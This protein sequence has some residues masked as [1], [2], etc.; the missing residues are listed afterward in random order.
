MDTPLPLPPIQRM[1]STPPEYREKD[2][3]DDEAKMGE[4]KQGDDDENDTGAQTNDRL[5]RHTVRA[6][7]LAQISPTPYFVH[8]NKSPWRLVSR[9]VKKINASGGR[10]HLPCLVDEVD[11]LSPS[12]SASQSPTLSDP[13]KFSFWCASNLPLSESDRLALLETSST[14]ERL[15]LVDQ[16]VEELSS[17][18]SPIVCARCDQSLSTV[19]NV[20]TVQGAEG[21]T[22]AYVNDHGYIHQ[23][24][25]LRHVDVQSIVLEGVPHEEN[26]YFPGYSWTVCYCRSC[27]SLLGWMFRRVHHNMPL[28]RDRPNAFFG[29][30]SSSVLVLEGRNPISPPDHSVSDSDEGSTSSSP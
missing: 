12:P 16:H 25:T 22:S 9:V 21:T 4:T 30:Q 1:F 27:L 18:N 29:F 2:N 17:T 8:R 24:T 23:I 11:A 5:Y 3:L 13:T 19:Q 7:C 14:Y 10:N 15:L 20:F 28:S 6:W 26:S